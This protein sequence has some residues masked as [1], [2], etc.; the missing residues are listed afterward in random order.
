MSE[1]FG[2]RYVLRFLS[3]AALSMFWGAAGHGADF[4]DGKQIT[5]VAS[6]AS[7]SGYDLYARTVA[8]WLPDHL[9]GHPGIVVQNM[10]GASGLRATN[11]LY[12]VAPK[13]GLTI[14]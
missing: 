4:Y 5:F 11:F 9:P 12:N 3:A 13:D 8:R 1:G 6:T 10:P 7:G 2:V 14:G